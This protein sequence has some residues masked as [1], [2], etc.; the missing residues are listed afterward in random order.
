MKRRRRRGTE[1]T[2]D[3]GEEGG[4]G[5]GGEEEEEEEEVE[6]E[7]EEEETLT[8]STTTVILFTLPGIDSV[9]KKEKKEK[10]EASP[11][12][13]LASTY[14]RARRLFTTG[15]FFPFWSKSK[16]FPG[17]QFAPT[18]IS[19]LITTC[20]GIADAPRTAPRLQG[21]GIDSSVGL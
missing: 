6:G 7:E 15:S 17:L 19:T 4:G 5:G 9:Y 20:Q 8:S 2:E 21:L 18:P 13:S 10:K 1:E 14:A 16:H 12:E 11:K 3:R